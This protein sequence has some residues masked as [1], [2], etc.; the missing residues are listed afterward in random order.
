MNKRSFLTGLIGSALAFIPTFGFAE[1]QQFSM[2]ELDI[3]KNK[4]VSLIHAKYSG[5]DTEQS[6]SLLCDEVA[7]LLKDQGINYSGVSVPLN[8]PNDTRSVR[9]YVAI[10]KTESSPYIHF[11]VSNND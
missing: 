5:V 7:K 1:D 4:I 11:R 8:L 3:L 2:E 9:V 6:R 10:K